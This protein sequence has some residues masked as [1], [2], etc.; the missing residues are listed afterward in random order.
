MKYL[1]DSDNFFVRQYLQAWKGDCRLIRVS[2]FFWNAGD[3]LQRSLEGL[4][5]SIL[6]QAL[7]ELPEMIPQVFDEE[8]NVLYWEDLRMPVLDKAVSK[9][10]QVLDP[11]R[12]KLCLFIDGLDEYEGDSFDQAQ[13]VKKIAF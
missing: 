11:Q 3:N 13:L 10:I 9:L 12:H 5:R 2:V 4:Y 6:Y 1:A 7:R 8:Q